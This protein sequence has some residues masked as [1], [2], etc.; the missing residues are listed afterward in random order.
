MGVLPRGQGEGSDGEGTGGAP[1]N[2]CLDPEAGSQKCVH[3]GISLTLCT[4]AARLGAYLQVRY[5]SIQRLVC[6]SRL[7]QDGWGI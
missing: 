6:K 5:S 1:G 3:L 2:I 7:P 4:G